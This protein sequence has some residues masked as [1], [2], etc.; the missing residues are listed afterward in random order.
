MENLRNTPAG[1]GPFKLE[2]W[3]PGVEARYVRNEEYWRK[4]QPYLDSFIQRVFPDPE[5]MVAAYEA[6][7]VDI[8]MYPSTQDFERLE[9]KA[10]NAG[11]K[12]YGCC[13]VNFNFNT[14]N[15][16]WDN[17]LVRQA[18]NHAIDRQRLVDIGFQGNSFAI[19]QPVRSG[20]AHNP[21][22]DDKCKFDL[23]LAKSLLAQAGYSDGFDMEALVSS[24]VM[25][26]STVLAQI[27]K[28]DLAKIGV[29]LKILDLEQTAYNNMGD[30]SLYKDMYI[31]IVGRTNK[32][33]G[34]LHSLTVAFRPETN[35]AKFRNE[36]YESLVLKG[37]QTVDP[38]ERKKIYQRLAEIVVDEVFSGVVAP[39]PELFLM[40]DKVR[41]FALSRD[42]ILYTGQLWRAK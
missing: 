18:I 14:A 41:G 40:N 16:P 4:G 29:N 2:E 3:E 32:D 13:E 11:Y 35:V 31:Q 9:G 42:G 37:L 36:E 22:L 10:G 17:K 27:M 38:E 6:G 24:T 7:T 28:D 19:C 21:T 25:P 5:A 39:R 26:E 15:K 20:W 23:D 30:K 12:A 33:P 34:S 1:T 8:V